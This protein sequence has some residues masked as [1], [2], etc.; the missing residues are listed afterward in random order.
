MNRRVAGAV[1][2]K[3]AIR[4][5]HERLFGRGRGRDDAHLE[6]MLAQPAQDVGLEPEIV[7][8]DPV[9]HRRKLLE[10]IL[11]GEGMRTSRALALDERP[12]AAEFALGIPVVG[13]LAGDFLDE[14][15]IEIRPFRARSTAAAS[16]IF[17]RG[18][19]AAQRALRA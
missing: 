2:E 10:V 6:T 3:N 18:Q 13:L 17:S 7:G 16:E 5:G 12:L 9:F 4:I 15:A 1:G 11:A 19:H 14:I 8:D